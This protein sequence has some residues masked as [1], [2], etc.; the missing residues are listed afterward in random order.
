MKKYLLLFTTFL[1]IL[2]GC[3]TPDKTEEISE[4]P[5]DEATEETIGES[6]ET[7]TTEESISEELT[8]LGE[9][10]QT[11]WSITKS[12]DVFYLTERE[13][14]IVKIENG[15][16]ERYEVQLEEE[17]STVAEAGLLGF[18][19]D[20][21]FEE[22]RAAIAYYT[23][24][25]KTGPTNR[26]VRLVFEE[27]TWTETNLLLDDIPSGDFHHGGRLALGP[28]EKLYATTGDATVPELA[29]DMDSLAGK[30]LR[31]NLDGSIPD[32]NPTSDSYVYSS[33][34]RNAQGLT[35]LEDGTMY[36]SEHG[37]QANDEVNVIDAGQNYG[38]PII[39]GEQA[40]EG[41][42]TPTFTSGPDRTWAPSGMASYEDKLYVAGL[43]GQAIYEFDLG[44]GEYR[45]VITDYGRIRTIYI[46]EDHLYYITNNTDGRGNPTDADDRLFRIG[47][48]EFE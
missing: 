7:A 28:D 38:W 6:Q 14:T 4:Q 44:I 48:S 41:L 40:Q 30:I 27:N 25:G 20:L 39:E 37:N 16:V 26:I 23:Y 31:M 1:L 33:G 19:L 24:E 15:E 35:W 10:L 45:E 18:V 47:L 5:T 2:V 9:K 29:Q 21:D 11:P 43:R 42:M 13:G 8:V 3:T 36:A 12:D 17:L 32:D 34:H 46:E 22:N